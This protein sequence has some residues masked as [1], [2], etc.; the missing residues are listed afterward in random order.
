MNICGGIPPII[1]NVPGTTYIYGTTGIE[2]N[3]D[4][5]TTR[6]FPYWSGATPVVNDLLISGRSAGLLNNEAYLKLD[7]VSSIK[8]KK[9]DFQAVSSIN[10]SSSVITLNNVST[11]NGLPYPASSAWNGNATTDLNMNNFNITSTNKI[12]FN[13]ATGFGTAGL[14]AS[15]TP[16]G[17][18]T[19][20]EVIDTQSVTSPPLIKEIRTLGVFLPLGTN[21]TPPTTYATDLEIVNL[22]ATGR[23]GVNQYTVGGPGGVSTFTVALQ[24]DPNTPYDIYVSPDGVDSSPT[25]GY[26]PGKLL[27]PYQTIAFALQRRSVLF[28][29][30]V[31]VTIHLASGTYTESFTM[32]RNTYIVGITTGESRQPCNIV[33]NITMNDT[34]GSM[35]LSGLEIVGNVSMTG[36][37]G[38]YTLFG[39]NI[40][41]GASTAVSATTGS[42]FITECRISNTAGSC[43]T[44]AST[45]IIRD[46][47]IS[48]TGTGSCVVASAGTSIRQSNI[49]SSSASTGV[50]PLVNI[51]NSNPATINLGFNRI[52]YTNTTTDVTGNKCCIKFA[53]SGVATANIYQSLL[54]CEGAITGS[55]QIQCIQDTGAGA[56]NISYGG[57][58]AGA[59]AHHISPNATKTAFTPVP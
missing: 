42:V 45:I 5:Y 29:T 9:I 19:V 54:L 11:I 13:S 57:L 12:G 43:L 28:P 51:T 59:T 14:R 52:E 58:L 17:N 24:S 55:P 36:L 56:V 47:V 4:V 40:N 2:L 6:V 31:E 18:F 37:G 53:G 25:A 48:T 22:N 34:T 33:G 7:L 21:S 10:I 46:C 16:P 1:P 32:A 26:G 30:N 20:M 44:C 50:A 23:I 38:S 49:S 41:G 35:G 3:S 8:G 27:N 15:V 39:C